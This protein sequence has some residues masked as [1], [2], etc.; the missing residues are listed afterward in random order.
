MPGE[1][2]DA[3]MGRRDFLK[4]SSV[5][6]SE[7]PEKYW[8]TTR[9][10]TVIME[11]LPVQFSATVLALSKCCLLSYYYDIFCK[12]L[13]PD[14]FEMHITDTNSIIVALSGETIDDCI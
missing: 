13:K 2:V 5:G 12:Y 1:K 8:E 6:P 9:R 7:N 3:A 14:S 10:K 11:S 4:M